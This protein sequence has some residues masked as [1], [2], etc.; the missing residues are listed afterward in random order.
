ME[1]AASGW[2][3]ETRL[4]VC[5]KSIETKRSLVMAR[6][7]ESAVSF[8]MKFTLI[9]VFLQKRVFAL[10]KKARKFVRGIGKGHGEKPDVYIQ[11]LKV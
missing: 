3:R 8:V 10:A 5:I 1:K 9:I 7:G 4:G 11:S 2:V 6:V